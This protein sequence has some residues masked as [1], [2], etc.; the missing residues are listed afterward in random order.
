MSA[1]V[2][3]A[4]LAIWLIF[5]RDTAPEAIAGHD[6]R[7]FSTDNGTATDTHQAPYNYTEGDSGVNPPTSGRHDPIPADCGTHDERVPDANLVHTLEHGAVGVLYDPQVVE[8]GDIRD[9][10]GIVSD[11]EED[12]LSAPYP[13]M[14]DPITVVSWSRKMGLDELDGGAIRE[15]IDTFIDTE[16]AP[17]ASAQTCENTADDAF[18]PPEPSPAPSPPPEEEPGDDKDGV[19]GDKADGQPSGE[20]KGEG[21]KGGD[22]PGGN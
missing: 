5:L 2:G 9:I 11:Y 8:L 14:P 17:E 15:Y 19:G 3:L 18:E 13:G 1:L 12:T 6:I 21:K 20:K 16:P 7:Q 4:A 22:G 10:E